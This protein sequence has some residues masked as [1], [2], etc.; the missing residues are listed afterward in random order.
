[1][2]GICWSEF[3]RVMCVEEGGV[4]DKVHT[5]GAILFCS[6]DSE[7]AVV[8]KEE[9]AKVGAGERLSCDNEV[10]GS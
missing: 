3:I 9:L 2:E 4:L 8:C 5:G 10:P 6:C 7:G 1:M